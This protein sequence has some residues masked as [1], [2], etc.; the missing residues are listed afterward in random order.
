VRAE[1]GQLVTN[2]SAKLSF[3]AA[4]S[5]FAF[6]RQ[7][8]ASSETIF[9]SLGALDLDSA[10][11]TVN[12]LANGST[13]VV[14]TLSASGAVTLAPVGGAASLTI[15][16][17]A[18][19][20]GVGAPV[21]VAGGPGSSGNIGGLTTVGA[22]NGATPGTNKGGGVRIQLGQVV[23]SVSALLDVYAGSTELCA[24]NS[25]VS[26]LYHQK[27]TGGAA[28]YQAQSGVVVGANDDTVRTYYA[29]GNGVVYT[30]GVNAVRSQLSGVSMIEAQ[31]VA[32]GRRAVGLCVGADL[33]TTKLPANTGD[34]VVF[35]G[36]CATVP[37]ASSNNTG[38]LCYVDAGALYCRETNGVIDQ[39]HFV[40]DASGGTLKRTIRVL[41]RAT[42][43]SATT[44]TIATVRAALMPGSGVG[45]AMV[46][47]FGYDTTDDSISGY[48]VHKVVIKSVGG[49]VSI[50]NN[51]ALGTDSFGGGTL[52]IDVS[53]DVRIRIA[54]KDTHNTR[55]TAT[56]DMHYVEH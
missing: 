10:T 46:R 21:T 45:I 24:I 19:T 32:V 41:G 2:Q 20:S 25:N 42:T 3:R 9:S 31:L 13:S 35:W 26:Y 33:D 40:D 15:Q 28:A 47:V 36:N 27:T 39:V 38:L 52:T 22:N 14:W 18:K 16:P 34:R 4:G 37:T 53:T 5:E 23:S 54:C 7:Q 55:W 29:Q 49:T 30:T 8:G 12:L 50:V 56:V 17:A 51:E 6:I 44:T 1:L 43:T 48:A 11:S